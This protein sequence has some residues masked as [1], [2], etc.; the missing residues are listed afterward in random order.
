[1][2]G[3]GVRSKS[4]RAAAVADPAGANGAAAAD[5]WAPP[6]HS[7]EEIDAIASA[8]GT[9]PIDDLDALAGTFWPEDESCDEFIVA[10]RSWRREGTSRR[11]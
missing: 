4:K 9:G 1:M 2:A 6:Q 11:R 7:P 5:P 3:T 10:Y 8:Q